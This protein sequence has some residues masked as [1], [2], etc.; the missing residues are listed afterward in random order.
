MEQEYKQLLLKDLCA[1]L[2]YGVIASPIDCD[3][4]KLIGFKNDDPILFDLASQKEYDKPWR[5]E[6]IKPYL[7]SMSS[8]TDEEWKEFKEIL[9]DAFYGGLPGT[10]FEMDW[11]YKKMFDPCDLIGKGLAI[12]APEGMYNVQ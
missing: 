1:R 10:V 6:Y 5:I 8:M 12:D 4:A 7:R 2:P 11:I 9:S 3:K